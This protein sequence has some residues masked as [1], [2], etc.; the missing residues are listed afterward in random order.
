[1]LRILF[2][3]ESRSRMRRP[4]APIYQTMYGRRC[5]DRT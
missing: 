2:L 4:F 1:M 5:V 3:S